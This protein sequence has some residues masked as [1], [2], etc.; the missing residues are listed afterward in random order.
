MPLPKSQKNENLFSALEV[1][2]LTG[3]GIDVLIFFCAI[4]FSY[5]LKIILF[6]IRMFFVL[7]DFFF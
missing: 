7:S 1:F 4:M 6:L 3:L 5:S 2:L